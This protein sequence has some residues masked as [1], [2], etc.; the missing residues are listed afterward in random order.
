MG[1]T[2]EEV[3]N[4]LRFALELAAEFGVRGGDTHRAVIQVTLT[5]INTAESNQG[6]GSKVKFFR[7]QNARNCDVASIAQSAIGAQ[8][9][10]LAQAV[11]HEDLLRFSEP[12]FPRQA[13]VFD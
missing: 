10:T 9:D 12:Q 11:Q 5:H 13:R 3:H 6:D 8:R 7:T 1:D 4:V 2:V